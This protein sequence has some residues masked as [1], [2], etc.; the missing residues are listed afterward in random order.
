[1]ALR[2]PLQTQGSQPELQSRS[3]SDIGGEGGGRLELLG[4]RLQLLEV[5]K[6]VPEVNL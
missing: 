5:I 1:M 2:G 4:K 6:F 3:G